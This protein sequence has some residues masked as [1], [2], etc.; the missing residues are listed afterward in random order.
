MAWY[1]WVLLVYTVGFALT[2]FVNMMV[3]PLT[4]ELCLVRA[5]IWPWWLV[6]GQPRGVPLTMD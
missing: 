1:W 5:L 4:F 2:L 3:G 6:T